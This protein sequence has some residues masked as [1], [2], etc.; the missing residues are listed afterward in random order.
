MG[1]GF[2]A[3][4][5]G[6]STSASLLT[7]ANQQGGVAGSLASA[8]SLGAI[9]SALAVMPFYERLPDA[10]YAVVGILAGMVLAGAIVTPR[11]TGVV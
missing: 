5:L 8:G 4:T 9:V 11:R 3:T 10:P 7:R 1:A 2:G 6:L